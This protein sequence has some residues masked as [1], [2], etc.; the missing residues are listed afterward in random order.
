[1]AEE[2]VTPVAVAKK[3]PTLESFFRDAAGNRVMKHQIAVSVN[4]KG[5]VTAVVQPLG[6]G[7][8][9]QFNVEGDNFVAV[10]E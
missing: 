6:G 1:M 5:K 4:S 8:A 7:V 9:R 10:D 2:K 3:G